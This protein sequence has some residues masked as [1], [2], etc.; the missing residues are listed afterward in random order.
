M[1]PT[2][3]KDIICSACTLRPSARSLLRL[4]AL[5]WH[6]GFLQLYMCIRQV[7]ATCCTQM[8]GVTEYVSVVISVR[9]MCGMI[10][11]LKYNQMD[12]QSRSEEL[13]VEM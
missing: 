4:Q 6:P 3:L 13:G 9:Y 10:T 8:A 7:F 2:C 5:N 11:S 1:V 12:L